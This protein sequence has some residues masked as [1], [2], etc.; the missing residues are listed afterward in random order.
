MISGDHPILWTA[1]NKPL[2][3]FSDDASYSFYYDNDFNR[4]IETIYGEGFSRVKI[5]AS[6]LY[7]IEIEDGVKT[8]RRH[9]PTPVGVVGVSN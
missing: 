7:Q 1:F 4:V 2:S 8:R 9:I 3:I 5:N 6:S